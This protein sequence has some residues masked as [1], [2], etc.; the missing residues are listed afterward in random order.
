MPNFHLIYSKREKTK[1]EKMKEQRYTSRKL[2]KKELRNEIVN[3]IMA[4]AERDRKAYS[5]ALLKWICT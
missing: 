2:T 4:K 3:G 5:I 1:G